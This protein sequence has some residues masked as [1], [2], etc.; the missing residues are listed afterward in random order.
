MGFAEIIRMAL[1]AL[2]ANKLRSILTMLGVAIGVFSV[3]GVMTALSVIQ[4]SIENGLSFLGSNIFQFAKYPVINAGGNEEVKYANRR[5]ISLAQAN[6][7]KRLMEGQANVICFK[8]FDR[9]KPASYDRKKI[10]GLTLIGT[11]ENFL[12]ANSFSIAYG[13]NLSAEDVDLARSVV[14][15]GKAIEKK[16]FPNQTPVGKT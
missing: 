3:I 4:V 9:G 12:T 5:N 6:E 16:L 11:N 8:V 7:F 15:V 2:R 13:R 10:Q 1:S 14:V